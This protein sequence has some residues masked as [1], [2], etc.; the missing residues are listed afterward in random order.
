MN[1]ATLRAMAVAIETCQAATIKAQSDC[2]TALR[3]LLEKQMATKPED[4]E[5]AA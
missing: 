1:E 5:N 4:I 3:Q 2:I